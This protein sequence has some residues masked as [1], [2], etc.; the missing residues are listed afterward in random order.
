[1]N[2]SDMVSPCRQLDG[3]ELSVLA[4][5]ALVSKTLDWLEMYLPGAL[6]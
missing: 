4:G 5:A 1:M 6:G 3:E 2:F